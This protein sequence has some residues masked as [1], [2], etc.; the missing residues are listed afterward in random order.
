MNNCSSVLQLKDYFLSELE[1]KVNE[2]AYNENE[3]DINPKFSISPEECVGHIMFEF[4]IK[5]ERTYANGVLIGKFIY[6]E[7]IDEDMA[8]ELLIV[9]GVTILF[10]YLRAVISNVTNIANVP[11]LMLPTVNVIDYLKEKYEQMDSE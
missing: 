6:D 1:F 2:D 7:S 4:S 9:N 8:K 11:T 3:L 5:D 10:P